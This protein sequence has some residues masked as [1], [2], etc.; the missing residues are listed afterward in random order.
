MFGNEEMAMKSD[1]KKD[2]PQQQSQKQQSQ[3]QQPNMLSPKQQ[4]IVQGRAGTY[5]NGQSFDEG[6]KKKNFEKF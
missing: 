4:E 1:V 5:P 6:G 3:K 2:Q